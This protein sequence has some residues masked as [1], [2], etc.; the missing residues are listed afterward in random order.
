MR[1]DI[2]ATKIG[3]SESSWC[4]N[5]L[6]TG[7]L[8][9]SRHTLNYMG[10]WKS[11][12]TGWT[13]LWWRNVPS[14]MPSFDIMHI[15]LQRLGNSITKLV[16]C[17]CWPGYML[18]NVVKLGHIQQHPIV[19]AIM[20]RIPFLFLRI[21]GKHEICICNGETPGFRGWTRYITGIEIFGC[22]LKWNLFKWSEFMYSVCS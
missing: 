1:F 14:R 13:Y 7:L 19:T 17:T 12:H 16:P 18:S 20:P 21:L 6:P 5:Q 2:K 10:L 22:F 8:S 4:S 11:T 3:L 15:V 9:T